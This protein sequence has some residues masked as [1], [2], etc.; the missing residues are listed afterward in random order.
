[1]FKLLKEL[2]ILEVIM[3]VFGVVLVAFGVDL[4][5]KGVEFIIFALILGVFLAILGMCY[6]SLCN[7]YLLSQQDILT[8]EIAELGASYNMVVEGLNKYHN[9]AE[10]AVKSKQTLQ[11]ERHADG[12][13]VATVVKSPNEVKRSERQSFVTQIENDLVPEGLASFNPETF[14]F[15]IPVGRHEIRIP[16][17]IHALGDPGRIVIHSKAVKVEEKKPVKTTT[18]KTKAKK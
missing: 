16:F 12:E 1:M 18:K 17:N 13:I 11:F 14:K 7:R 10:N 5:I 8:T 4:L 3:L 15:I 2:T 9:M 6:Y